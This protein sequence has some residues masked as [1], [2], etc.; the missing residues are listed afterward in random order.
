MSELELFEIKHEKLEN[1]VEEESK[2]ES[3]RNFFETMP[4]GEYIRTSL[5][6]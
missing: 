5:C 2:T 6:F 4:N 3:G 1:L